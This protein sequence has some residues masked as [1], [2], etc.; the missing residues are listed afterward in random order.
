[1]I[2]F[3]QGW[4]HRTDSRHVARQSYWLSQVMCNSMVLFLSTKYVLLDARC[5]FIVHN[6]ILFPRWLY[7]EY[8]MSVL[9]L[10]MIKEISYL[11][12]FIF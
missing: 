3:M 12:C 2:R 7:F 5:C 8:F 9:C 1:M 10:F 6:D 11:V 4:V